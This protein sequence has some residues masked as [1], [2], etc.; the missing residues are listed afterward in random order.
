MKIKKYVPVVLGLIALNTFAGQDRGGGNVV[1][2]R[3]GD[4]IE[5]IELLDYYEGRTRRD[6][7]IDMGTPE[8]SVDAIIDIALNRLEKF[9]PSKAKS[10]QIASKAFLANSRFY[11]NIKLTGIEDS[12][13]LFL[14]ANCVLEQ[15]AV[16]IDRVFDEDKTYNINQDI[17]DQ[18]SN[19][20]KAGLILHEIIYSDARSNN[21]KDSSIS[22]RLNAF[23]ASRE[24]EDTSLIEFQKSLKGEIKGGI[25]YNGLE[26]D[27][28][29]FYENEDSFGGELLEPNQSIEIHPSDQIPRSLYINS[30]VAFYPNGSLYMLDPKK[31]QT[32]QVAAGKPAV[33]TP[34]GGNSMFFYQNG[35]IQKAYL[36]RRKIARLN[37]PVGLVDFDCKDNYVYF[38]ENGDYQKGCSLVNETIFKVNENFMVFGRNP[39][40][41]YKNGKIKSGFL[42]RP[43]KYIGGNYS[44]AFSPSAYEPITFSEKGFLTL[45]NYVSC[46]IGNRSYKLTDFRRDEND[47]L[48]SGR[49]SETVTLKNGYQSLALPVSSWLAFQQNGHLEKACLAKPITV[50]FQG[51]KYK[52]ILQLSFDEKENINGVSTSINDCQL[53]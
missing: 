10:Y 33:V 52:N 32:I 48:L 6:F 23:I 39:I 40:E 49:I 51:I 53:Y 38:Y 35:T 26:I 18:L 46:E 36:D 22:R 17:W 43:G 50:I 29:T 37:T 8:M 14:P 28:E 13:H 1:I 19:V 42:E 5:S 7:T 45:E 21:A 25:L 20:N 4:K 27:S 2:C 16:Q 44:V 12:R 3:K 9:M 31:D 24:I 15:A 11:K 30:H 47:N 41:F 34:L